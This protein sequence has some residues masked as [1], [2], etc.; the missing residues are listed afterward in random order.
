MPRIRNS[1]FRKLFR[2]PI[3]NAISMRL[4]AATGSR[5]YSVYESGDLHY[6]LF[7]DLAPHFSMAADRMAPSGLAIPFP[8]MSGAEP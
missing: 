2:R 6:G 4:G 3:N 5:G 1:S 7:R 8:A